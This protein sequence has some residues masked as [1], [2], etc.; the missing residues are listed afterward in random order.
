[1]ADAL[2]TPATCRAARALLDW[3]RETL[4]KASHVGLRTLVD[5][6]RGAREPHYATLEAL[7]RALEAAGVQFRDDAAGVALGAG[8]RAARPTD[9]VVDL[10]R[11]LERPADIA[12]VKM[13]TEAMLS[14]R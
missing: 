1:M 5:F 12:A 8:R 4:A 2:I 14:R 3:S 7:R 10:V 6:E 9:E 11:R 13:F